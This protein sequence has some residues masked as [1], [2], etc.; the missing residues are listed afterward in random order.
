MASPVPSFRGTDHRKSSSSTP[1]NFVGDSLRDDAAV[2]FPA[3]ASA[4]KSSI[5]FHP[6]F[7]SLWRRVKRSDAGTS[8]RCRTDQPVSGFAMEYTRRF[9]HQENFTDTAQT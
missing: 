3:L 4:G 9:F 8:F 2:D 6:R 5:I 1:R 7:S